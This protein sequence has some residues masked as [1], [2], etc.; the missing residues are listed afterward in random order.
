MYLFFLKNFKRIFFHNFWTIC[1]CSFWILLCYFRCCSVGFCLLLLLFVGYYWSDIVDVVVACYCYCY[2]CFPSYGLCCRY[3]CCCCCCWVFVSFYVWGVCIAFCESHFKFSKSSFQN[4]G[5]FYF[6]S[7]TLF[8]IQFASR[9]CIVYFFGYSFV[10]N[11]FACC[12]CCSFLLLFV[13]VVFCFWKKYI[14][15]HFCYS[16]Y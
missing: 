9:R 16:V 1:I 6:F 12:C 7:F 10:C 11:C 3:C 4:I 13:A 14:L 2:C 8:H 15:L 5:M